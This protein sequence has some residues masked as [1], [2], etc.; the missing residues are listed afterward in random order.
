MKT[1]ERPLYLDQLIAMYGTPAIKVVIGIRQSGKSV[2][3]EQYA[4]W[5]RMKHPEANIIKVDMQEFEDV[6][7]PEYLP[8]HVYGFALKHYKKGIVNLLIIDGVKLF[9]H[10]EAETNIF[11]A[12]GLF[13]IYITGSNTFLQSSDFS[14]LFSGRTMKL[15]VF[16][17]S[18]EEFLQ[19]TERDDLDVAFSDY[20]HLG[21]FPGSYAYKDD[22]QKYAYIREITTKYQIRNKNELF[23][24]ASFLMENIGIVSSLHS[25][26]LALQHKGFPITAKTVSDSI[27]YFDAAFIFHK[28]AQFDIRGKKLL[29]RGY[30]YYLV[31]IGLRYAFQGT[32]NM[33]VGRIY[34]NLVYLELVR[35]GYEVYVG[36]LYRKEID[37]VVKKG[38]EQCYIQVSDDISEPETLKREC[39]SLLSIKDAYP[40]MILARTH[41]EA[42]S[43]DGI[44]IKDLATWLS[45]GRTD[46]DCYASDVV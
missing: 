22:S 31:D 33:D 42:Y 35:R 17:F 9:K 15:V 34:E 41:H 5:V 19:Y 39:V 30:K 29:K 36:K 18:F 43:K 6:D 37:F 13:D 38:D 20:V 10:F 11:Y 26:S 23:Q 1:I 44:Q 16:P 28:V 46:S 12:R 21:G 3:M 24:I 7:I 40:K 45:T 27:Q 14:T 32:K 25:M 2:L 8:Y 4:A